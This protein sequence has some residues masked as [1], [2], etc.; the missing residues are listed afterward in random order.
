MEEKCREYCKSD[1]DDGAGRGDQNHVAARVVQGAKIDGHTLGVAE[2]ER[3][4]IDHVR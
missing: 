2:Q 4:G 1:I 3:R